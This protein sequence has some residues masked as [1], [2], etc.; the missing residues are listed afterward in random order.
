[1]RGMCSGFMHSAIFNDKH[2]LNYIFCASSTVDSERRLCRRRENIVGVNTVLAEHASKLFIYLFMRKLFI[3]LFICLLCI[4]LFR[5]FHIKHPQ[6]AS[7]NYIYDKHVWIRGYSAKAMFTPT[8][9]SRRR[10][11]RVKASRYMCISMY[12][13]CTQIYVYIY[14]YIH[15]YM[16]TTTTLHSAKG[17][18]VETGCS[19]L[20]DDV[21]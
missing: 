10:L 21:Y 13:M 17:G 11:W 16:K 12:I 15:R 3:C 18:A 19:D 9:F 14:I 20:Y 7:S 6:I 4:Y 5:R 8:T 1:M 2:L